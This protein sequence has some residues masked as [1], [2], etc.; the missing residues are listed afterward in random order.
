M[1]FGDVFEYGLKQY[2]YLG[3]TVDVVYAA[4]ILS[5]E[6]SKKLNSFCETQI[7][8]NNSST[9]KW[10]Y[11]Y[12]VLTTDELKDRAAQFGR[13]EIDDFGT[14]FKKLSISL[15]DFDLRSLK[16]DIMGSRVVPLGLKG[17]ISEVEIG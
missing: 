2:I 14:L 3:S 9:D 6:E 13:P 5:T 10:L 17:I 4:R 12:V 11:C 7:R 1:F 16:R 8:K 15:T